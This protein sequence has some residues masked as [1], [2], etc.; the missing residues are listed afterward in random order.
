MK[1]PV[2]HSLSYI[3]YHYLG[4][5]QPMVISRRT[6]LDIEL[7]EDSNRPLEHKGSVGILL[8]PLFFV[9]GKIRERY[10]SWPQ[11]PLN[12]CPE[13]WSHSSI[14]EDPKKIFDP[15][16]N[17]DMFHFPLHFPMICFFQ[18]PE[19]FSSH[20]LSGGPGW[21]W[22]LIPLPTFLSE[23]QDF[24][25]VPGLSRIWHLKVVSLAVLHWG[26]L[27]LVY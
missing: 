1:C 20:H 17:L 19:I 3:A 22:Y 2:C 26:E 25:L 15:K 23:T 8:T 7:W 24:L 16:K 4:G 18:P 5:I 9:K 10:R 12:P 11:F 27:I 21:D 13:V 14:F 6:V